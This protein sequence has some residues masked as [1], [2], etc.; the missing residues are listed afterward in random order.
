MQSTGGFRLAAVSES[1]ETRKLKPPASRALK[2]L[3]TY[4]NG[5]EKPFRCEVAVRQ[6]PQSITLPRG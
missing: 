3:A 2:R 6:W 5:M 4:G 1:T